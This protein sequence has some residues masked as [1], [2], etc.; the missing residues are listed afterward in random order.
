MVKVKPVEKVKLTNTFPP[1]GLYVVLRNDAL[2]Q[3]AELITLQIGDEA[4]AYT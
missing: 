1:E 3:T 2:I 4:N